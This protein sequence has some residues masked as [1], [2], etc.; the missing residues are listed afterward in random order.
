VISFQRRPAVDDVAVVLRRLGQPGRVVD[1]V[2]VEEH[3]LYLV[4][5]GQA[6]RSKLVGAVAG[7]VRVGAFADK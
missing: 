5:L 7:L 4:P 3:T 2:V 6:R 1:P